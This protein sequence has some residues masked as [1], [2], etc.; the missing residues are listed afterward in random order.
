MY[1]VKMEHGWHKTM[2][3]FE[4]MWKASEFMKTAMDSFVP[5]DKDG[6]DFVIEKVDIKKEETE[7]A[8]AVCGTEKD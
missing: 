1:V 2:F 7:D 8:E 5:D 4:D 3:T 6:L